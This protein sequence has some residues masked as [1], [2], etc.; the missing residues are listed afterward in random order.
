MKKNHGKVR[1]RH[2]NDWKALSY[3]KQCRMLHLYRSRSPRVSACSACS[4]LFLS[5]ITEMSAMPRRHLVE[6]DERSNVPNFTYDTNHQSSQISA[7]AARD[8]IITLTF[9]E[10]ICSFHTH[11]EL[12]LSLQNSSPVFALYKFFCFSRVYTF[13]P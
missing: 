3:A 8:F 6:H 7:G 12:V 9:R 2:D 13:L 1:P 5:A 11:T 10:A 4:L